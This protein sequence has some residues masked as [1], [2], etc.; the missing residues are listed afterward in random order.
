MS[1]P[2]YPGQPYDGQPSSGQPYQ[3]N[4][5]Y[6]GQPYSG[7][8]YQGQQPYGQPN[9]DVPS[10]VPPQPG[11][12]PTQSYPPGDYGQQPQQPYGAGQ[13]GQ[14]QQQPYGAGDYGQQQPGFPPPGAPVP[15][16]KKSKVLPIVLISIAI[17]VVL[18]VG[19]ITAIVMVANNNDDKEATGT[20]Q[21]QDP[22]AAPTTPAEE[23]TTEAPR[24]STIQI[25]EPKTLG[26]R[27]KL[28]DAQFASVA[29]QLQDSLKDVPGATG[30]VGAL[31]GAVEKQNIVIVA[32]AEA[33]IEDP[34]K[35]L[36]NT[37]YGAGIGGMKI[38]NIS[39][40][41]TGSLG[42]SAKCGASET[43]GINLAI[44]AWADEGSL[45]MF[46]WFAKSVSKAKAEF[47]TLRAQVEKKS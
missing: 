22:T 38:T 20:T 35:E 5:P 6:S 29:K 1:Q 23:P 42:G 40:A 41:P 8:P 9:P 39:S 47:P 28:T 14:P 3:G 16:K 7:Q 12:P 25:V 27:P 17:V 10:S 13:F 34:A 26:G 30:S 43:S 4:Q 45:G 21:T 37:F 33:P 15:P 11:Y 31:Y 24:A 18:C 2:P 36:D 46:I 44:C 32:A 19:G